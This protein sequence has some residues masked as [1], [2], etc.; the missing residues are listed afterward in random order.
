LSIT[1]CDRNDYVTWHCKVDATNLD[2]KPLTMI[3][4][5][6]TMKVSQQTYNYCGSLGPTSYFDLNCC[7]SCKFVEKPSWWSP[8]GSW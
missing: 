4:E 1:A 8:Q 3:L 6:S 7:S 2:E 5:G